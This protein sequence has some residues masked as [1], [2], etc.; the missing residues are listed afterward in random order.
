MENQ[1]FA[2]EIGVNLSSNLINACLTMLALI[3][4]LFV[5]VLENREPTFLFYLFLLMSF[6]S[7]VLSIIFGGKAID[8]IRKKCFKN[9]L[10][11]RY[12]KDKFNWQA[13]FCII[14]I[15]LCITSIIF[16]KEQVKENKEIEAFKEAI[17]KVEKIEEARL[18][19]IQILRVRLDSVQVALKD[20]KRK[21]K[22]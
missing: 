20:I 7:F 5:F 9:K 13:L 4:A 18:H 22:L 3:G 1:R 10:K 15:L 14:G 12:S 17:L 8:I 21:K 19:E 11:L 16:T 6:T 2:I